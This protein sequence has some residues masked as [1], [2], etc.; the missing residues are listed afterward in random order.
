MAIIITKHGKRAKKIDKSRFINEDNLQNFIYENP[1]SIPLYDIDENIRLLILAREFP[2]NSGNIDA[3]GIDEKGE[4]Y[5]IE[6]K[7]YKNPDKRLVVA[8]VLDY[9]ASLSVSYNDKND[10]FQILETKVNQHFSIG[11]SQKICDFF[12]Y[13]KEDTVELINTLKSNI[14][15]G[16]FRFVVL[17]DK[18][19]K[20]LRDLILFLNRNSR[21]DVY[22]VELEFYKCDDFEITIPK[23]FG[24]EIKKE[25]NTT[26]TTGHRKTWNEESF[27][28]EIEN[29]LAPKETKVIKNLYEFSKECA[30]RISWGTGIQRG[31]FSPIVSSICSRSIFTLFSDGTLQLNYAWINENDK[32]KEY[33]KKYMKLL[34]KIFELP[35]KNGKA[36]YPTYPI[37]EWGEKVENLKEIIIETIED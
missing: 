22:G 24:A 23:L 37:L 10:F 9:G 33:Q 3:L 27:F 17:M 15:N 4:L 18:L 6:T 32:Q 16:K 5:I 8:Q 26:S 12:G 19:E 14:I 28:E 29:N 25:I 36:K 21:F 13:S 35:I 20:R 31:S 34:G 2:T 30:D 7:L 1:D 11:L